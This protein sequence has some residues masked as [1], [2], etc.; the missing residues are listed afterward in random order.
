ML[1]LLHFVFSQRKNAEDIRKC[2]ENVVVPI[3][4]TAHAGADDDKKAKLSKVPSN[5]IIS[6]YFYCWVVHFC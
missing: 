3:F 4:C 1:L 5:A 2:I 6:D